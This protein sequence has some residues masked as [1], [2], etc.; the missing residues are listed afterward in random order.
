MKNVIISI[1]LSFSIALLAFAQEG[2][3]NELTSKKGVPVLPQAGDYALG[4]DATP[5]VN[6][7]GNLIKINS[8]SS[9]NDPS[10]FNYLDGDNTIYGKY[11]VSPSTAY[12]GKVRIA[13]FSETN[14]VYVFDDLYD[15]LLIDYDPAKNDVVDKRKTSYSSIIL[16][17]GLEKRRGYGRLQGFYGAEALLMY[18]K[19]SAF[20]PNIKYKFANK[21]TETNTSPT[22]GY[23]FL[24]TRTL[25]IKQSATF[26][27]GAR[28]FVGAEFFF[29]PKISVGGEFGWG[30]LYQMQGDTKTVTESWN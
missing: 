20:N 29:A 10:G 3:T 17:A 23:G 30:F 12:R 26:G 27:I 9:F 14:K 15:G 13:R 25:S 18:A 28:A 22:N 16:G 5:F 8:G 11:F 4:L 2:N 1:F 6:L 7:V 21:I 19:G 24:G